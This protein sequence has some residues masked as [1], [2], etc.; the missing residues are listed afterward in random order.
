MAFR[1][2]PVRKR[3]RICTPEA[4]KAAT[5]PSTPETVPPT[6]EG[7][8]DAA[9][10]VSARVRF[11]M[12]DAFCEEYMRWEA[13]LSKRPLQDCAD[14]AAD[15]LARLQAASEE[16]DDFAITLYEKACAVHKTKRLLQASVLAGG[17]REHF[18]AYSKRFG[19]KEVADSKEVFSTVRRTFCGSRVSA[20]VTEVAADHTTARDSLQA[21]IA[22]GQCLL[23]LA[24]AVHAEP[25]PALAIDMALVEHEGAVYSQGV[26]DHGELQ[27]TAGGVAQDG[28]DHR[29]VHRARVFLRFPR[30]IRLAQLCPQ[31]LLLVVGSLLVPLGMQRHSWKTLIVTSGSTAKPNL[32]DRVCADLVGLGVATDLKEV[33]RSAEHPRNRPFILKLDWKTVGKDDKFLDELHA[34]L[35][36]G[37]AV[38]LRNEVGV[39]K[40]ICAQARLRLCT[41]HLRDVTVSNEDTWSRGKGLLFTEA[42]KEY[43]LHA[44]T[45]PIPS[46]P[47]SNVL[48]GAG[49]RPVPRRGM[50]TACFYI[51][52]MIQMQYGIGFG[53]LGPDPK[54]DSMIDL[55]YVTQALQAYA[56]RRKIFEA[57]KAIT[58]EDVLQAASCARE[59]RHAV[60]TYSHDRKLFKNLV[61]FGV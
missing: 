28:G 31:D 17:I 20:F 5:V 3:S 19:W 53:D 40:E 21:S 58:V 12:N 25:M 54:P 43:A 51:T 38:V 59:D 37:V 45:V 41:T 32:I 42:L 26:T 50:N 55:E 10:N 52:E 2:L 29:P 47:F 6:E 4:A 44:G 61:K 24:Q 34:V 23:A 36:I 13:G 9:S 39:P 8:E 33:L 22:G 48:D 27:Y 7:F 15:V 1:L 14:L 60:V 18:Q 56:L 11:V 57:S 16:G 30:D 35:K 46:I 49:F